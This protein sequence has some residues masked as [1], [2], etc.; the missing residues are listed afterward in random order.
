[1]T[2]NSLEYFRSR[3]KTLEEE[4]KRLKEISKEHQKLNGK[5]QVELTKL[6]TKLNN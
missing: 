1:M 6:K 5:I 4:N 3:N 2:T